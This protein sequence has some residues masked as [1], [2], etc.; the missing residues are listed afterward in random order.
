MQVFFPLEQ[1]LR[2][3]GNQ[4]GAYVIG[5]FDCCRA[6]FEQPT[7]GTGD[8]GGDGECEIATDES[9]N[10]LLIFG[11]KPLGEVSAVSTVAI[12]FIEMVAS[13]AEQDGS[14]TLPT[15]DLLRWTP[16]DEGE[17]VTAFN[18]TLYFRLPTG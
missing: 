9:R 8:N 18:H 6:N 12:E 16:G 17:F 7:R 14:I 2:T 3:M 10:C 1:Q 11:C 4:N 5:V 13:C 15:M